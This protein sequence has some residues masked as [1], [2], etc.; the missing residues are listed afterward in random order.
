MTEEI[1][2]KNIGKIKKLKKKLEKALNASIAVSADKASIESKSEDAISEYFGL[3]ILEAIDLGFDFDTAMHLKNE[4]FMLEKIHLKDYARQSRLRAVRGRIIGKEGSAIRILSQLSDC[5]M[6]I[7]EYD[8]AVI[9]RTEDVDVC[10]LALKKL[11][12]GA[13]HSK[14]Y[15]FL[16][17]NRAIRQEKLEIDEEILKKI[18]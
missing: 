5:S 7:S 12:R 15:A 16:E 1:F 4:D 10:I 6:K 9:G 8:V 2:I 14:V 3:K 11:I 17:R 18:K 13:P